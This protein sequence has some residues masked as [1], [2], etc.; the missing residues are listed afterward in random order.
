MVGKVFFEQLSRLCAARSVTVTSALRAADGQIGSIG[1]WKRGSAPRSDLVVRLAD[2]L[3][4]ST[5]YLLGRTDDPT[6]VCRTTPGTLSPEEALL[7]QG[8]RAAVP[9]LREAL[10]LTNLTALSV[11]GERVNQ[12]SCAKCTPALS[13]PDRNAACHRRNIR[14]VVPLSECAPR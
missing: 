1:G 8:L 11:H 14:V 3:E 10:Y 4:T 5:D 2:Y 13:M 12:I 7:V 6:P 9:S